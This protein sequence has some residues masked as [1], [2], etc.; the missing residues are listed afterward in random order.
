MA[1]DARE[2]AAATC[3]EKR[4]KGN[5]CFKD[6]KFKQAI[7]YYTTA[8]GLAED[9]ADGRPVPKGEPT[10]VAQLAC[11]RCMAN[12]ALGDHVAALRDAKTAIASAPGWPKSHFRH[13]KVLTARGAYME[14]YGAFKQAWHLDPS[15]QELVVA[16]QQAY[17]RMVAHDK[18]KAQ[19]YA[20]R[21]TQARDD[22]RQPVVV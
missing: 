12:L 14:A 20:E 15:N 19:E 21:A 11:N 1:A 3:E 17:E 18:E 4:L 5:A 6:G 2:Q 8:L 9:L 7:K 22:A 13:A 10:L 16:C